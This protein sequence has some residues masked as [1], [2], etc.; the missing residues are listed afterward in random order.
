MGGSGTACGWLKAPPVL[1]K[2]ELWLLS[3]PNVPNPL[4]HKACQ[5]AEHLRI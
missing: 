1:A 3:Q 2:R 4:Q 5:H